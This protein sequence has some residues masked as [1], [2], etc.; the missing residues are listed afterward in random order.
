MG[1]YCYNT[2]NI[3]RYNNGLIIGLTA[4]E[5]TKNIDLKYFDSSFLSDFSNESEVIFCGGSNT[6]SFSAIYN[7]KKLHN[8]QCYISAIKMMDD[9]FIM[10]KYDKLSVNELVFNAFRQCIYNQTQEAHC[11]PSQIDYYLNAWC[12]SRKTMTI[13]IREITQNTYFTQLLTECNVITSSNQSNTV[14]IDSLLRLFPNVSKINIIEPIFDTKCILL[15]QIHQFLCGAQLF[16][17]LDLTEIVLMNPCFVGMKMSD[18][19]SEY[20][21]LFAD[22][23]WAIKMPS[24]LSQAETP[25][26][27]NFIIRII[28]QK[29]SKQ[30]NNI[31][32]KHEKSRSQPN[33]IGN[34]DINPFGHKMDAINQSA[35]ALMADYVETL[36]TTSQQSVK[37]SYIFTSVHIKMKIKQQNKE[38]LEVEFD[39]NHKENAKQVA[40]EMIEELKLPS[41]YKQ[42]IVGAINSCL[43]NHNTSKIY[44][45]VSILSF[46]YPDNIE[47][48]EQN[49]VETPAQNIQNIDHIEPASNNK[50]S[51]NPNSKSLG[52]I[53]ENETNKFIQRQTKNLRYNNNKT[54]YCRK[55][56]LNSMSYRREIQ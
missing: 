40:S 29:K 42:Q 3:D 21:L 31:N 52:I 45:N 19:M 50:P 24:D 13:N 14:S 4:N 38:P 17:G 46:F 22:A 54:I 20:L 39:F 41:N 27:D 55:N 7:I 12:I 11:I 8:Y 34:A 9:A 49:I 18:I 23:G 33:V 5:N 44:P 53:P 32:K 51:L 56:T 43:P 37:S 6:L 10:N 2:I 15:S 25:G 26:N 36:S 48:T 16:Y 1:Y 28:K 35:N 30:K 47:K